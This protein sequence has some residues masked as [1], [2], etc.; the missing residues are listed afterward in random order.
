M[1]RVHL[2]RLALGLLGIVVL[3]PLNA[4]VFFASPLDGGWSLA[5]VFALDV[6]G[7]LVAAWAWLWAGVAV[8]VAC[9]VNLPNLVY[10]GVPEA[11]EWAGLFA[12][13]AYA[14]F[15]VA[16]WVSWFRCRNQGETWRWVG[17]I[18]PSLCGAYIVVR[19]LMG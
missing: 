5:I 2:G 18:V 19:A 17:A 10:V 3:S 16:G 14:I 6:V 12:I 11:G 8:T 4:W 13:P 9:A 1:R 15:L 7:M